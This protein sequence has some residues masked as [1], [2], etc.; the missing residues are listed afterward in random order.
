[1][2]NQGIGMDSGFEERKKKHEEKWALDEQLRFKALARRNKLLGRWAAAELGMTGE[3]AE[4]YAKA[5]VGAQFHGEDG[6][7]RK[8]RDDLHGKGHSDEAI[9]QKMHELEDQARE[10]ILNGT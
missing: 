7:F 2:L 3:E 5:V 4:S 10:Q 8:V 9:H 6:A 1:M